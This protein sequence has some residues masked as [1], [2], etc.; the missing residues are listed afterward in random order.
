MSRRYD[1]GYQLVNVISFSLSRGL[2]ILIKIL[3]KYFFIK[4]KRTFEKTLGLGF[5]LVRDSDESDEENLLDK[6]IEKGFIDSIFGVS[7]ARKVSTVLQFKQTDSQKKKLIMTF[8]ACKFSHL[9]SL[10]Y[11]FKLKLN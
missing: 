7:S 9:D 10:Y 11:N 4:G 6:I 8:D 5:K 3:L 2:I 1:S